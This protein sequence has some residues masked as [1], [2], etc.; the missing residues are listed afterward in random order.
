MSEKPPP[1]DF[2]RARV[3]AD[4][5]SGR[6]RGRVATRFPPEPNG[7]LHIGHAKSIVL[8]FGI[9][10]EHGGTCNLRFDDTNPLTEDP[11]YVAAIEDDVRWLG[12]DW[13]DR[14]TFASDYF[15]R[16][17]ECAEEL[18]RRGLAYVD[19]ASEAEIQ[20]ARGTVSEPGR[21]TPGRE[22]PPEESLALLRRMR[23]G[24]L[25][26]GAA[27]LRAKIDLAAANMKMR[28]PLLYRIR[29]AHHYRTGDEWPIY[30]M[31]DFAHPLSDAFEGITH[32]L[33]TLEFENNRDIY[34][35]LVDNLGF[36]DP[37]PRQIE[38]ARLNL[39]YTVLSKRRL[40]ELVRGGHVAG[41]DDPRM[42][43]LSGLRRRGVTPEAI[44]AFC[45]RIGVAK[46]NSLVDVAQLEHSVRDDS[47]TR[48]PRVLAVLDPLAVTIVNYPEGESEELEAPFWPHDVGKPGSRK[49]PFSRRLWIERDDFREVP[50]RGFHRL[51]PGAEVRL[52]YGYLVR[53]EEVVKDERGKVVEL[54]CTYDPETRG[55]QA[56]DGRR[57]RG[58]LHWVSAEHA[59]PFEARL[60]D[61]LFLAEDPGAAEDWLS[62]LNPES[63]VVRERCW[64][65]PSLAE[66]AA[67]TH[68][69]FER[70]GYFVRDAVEAEAGRLVFN[71][72]VT[73]RDTWAKI[74]GRND[75]DTRS[76]DRFVDLGHGAGRAAA[77]AAGTTARGGAAAAAAGDAE[78]P[79]PPV[80][81]RDPWAGLAAEGREAAAAYAE[82]GLSA[83]DARVLAAD[84]DLG[85][86]FDEAR[87]RHANP[88]ALAAWLVNELPPHAAGRR[89]GELPFGPAEL[90]ELVALV[91]DGTIT[92][93]VAKDVL[94]E[95]ASRGGSPRAIVE[96]RGLRQL[97]DT[98]A[99]ATAVANVLGRHAEE[100]DRYHAGETRLLGF[101]VGRVMQETGGRANPQLVHELLRDRLA[102][103]DET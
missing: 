50:P 49:L 21:P 98:T 29:H 94:A 90:A 33:C 18:V 57:V 36:D 13:G 74:A 83:D 30:P 31:Y 1:T 77:A 66:A 96:A 91:D 48:A 53:C 101:F 61:R 102:R 63:L 100:V 79:T 4:L 70:L 17:Y 22:R 85:R 5:A 54:R 87:R 15:G 40:L 32:S 72:T 26:D 39:S 69:Q 3:A 41:W 84:P 93:T 27:V 11:E 35:W 103:H 37:R 88:R 75:D 81:P 99:V 10:E 64:G 51:S 20:E 16:L 46:A 9:A 78:P 62:L 23:A 59:V 73:L 92:G 58:T 52:R 97:S 71:R 67:G 68:Y 7:Y 8:N 55:G 80:T 2:I 14:E 12:Y 60:Y 65:E 42:P 76:E 86:F 43:T 56:P 38:F 45:G 82:L 19:E 6:D 24:E 25:A 28:D 47:N 95:I 44:R 34:D 89:P